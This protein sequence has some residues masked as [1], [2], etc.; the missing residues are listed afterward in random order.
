MEQNSQTNMEK[1]NI[2]EAQIRECF[3]R[4]VYSHKTQEKCADFLFSLN[5]KLKLTQIILSAIITTSLFVE[6]FGDKSK[7][8]KKY[9]LLIILTKTFIF[10]SSQEVKTEQKTEQHRFVYQRNNQ[11]IQKFEYDKQ[12]RLVKIIGYDNQ[13]N[14]KPFDKDI[15]ITINLYDGKGNLIEIQNFSENGKLI[16]AEFEDTPIIRMKYNEAKIGVGCN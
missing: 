10:C 7:Q 5:K 12:N 1:I 11:T 3:G 4:V 13:K 16:S 9:L 6:I 14:I 2:L 15:A 8:M